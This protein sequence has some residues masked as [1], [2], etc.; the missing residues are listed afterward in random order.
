MLSRSATHPLWLIGLLRIAFFVVLIALC[1]KIQI[2]VPGTPVPITLQVLSVLLAG[3]ILGPIEGGISAAA[4]LGAIALG[5][6]LDAYNHSA[7]AL[8]SPTAGFLIG[9]VPGAMLAGLSWRVSKYRFFACLVA[10]IA[11]LAAIYGL[12]VAGLYRLSGL[13]VT[14]IALGAIPFLLVDAAKVMLASSLVMLGRESWL[15]W[16]TPGLGR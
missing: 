8:L 6:P 15:R 7:A 13:W 1:A 3:M 11:G 2:P 9:F 12:G 10:G 16:I 14:A 4:Y 5:L